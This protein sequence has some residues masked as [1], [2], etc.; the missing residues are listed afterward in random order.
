MSISGTITLKD[1]TEIEITDAELVKGSL[2]VS[3]STCSSA[4]DIGSFNAA[5]MKI[6]IYDSDALEHEFDGAVIELTETRGETSTALGIY[7][8]DGTKTDRRGNVVKLTAYDAAVAFDIEI[9]QTMRTTSYTPLTALQAACTAAGIALATADISAYPNDAV[10]ISLASEQIQSLRDAVMWIAQLLCANAVINRSGELEI[11]RAKYL[12]VGSE[13]TVDHLITGAERVKTQ[14]S[15]VRTYIRY[16]SAYSADKVKDY[17]S[18]IVISDAQA[19]SAGFTLP[20]NP[21]ITGKSEAD[22]DTINAAWLE[23]IDGFMQRAVKAELFGRADIALGDT[24]R[25]SGGVIDVRRSI[26]GVI[27]AIKWRY[28]G[29]TTIQC[30][31]PQAVSKEVSS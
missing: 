31:A 14:F 22:C 9:P 24:C 10:G 4:F 27:T 13:I 29:N 30:H 25:F 8:V 20:D 17:T 26:V 28:N 18:N 7:Y 6:S 5:E 15:D 16:L 2:T 3:M 23:Y 1:N 21:L 19:R 12:S 11:R